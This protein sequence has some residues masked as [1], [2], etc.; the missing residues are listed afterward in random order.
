MGVRRKKKQ[1]KRQRRGS[2]KNA[3]QAVAGRI[4]DGSEWI[5]FHTPDCE[6]HEIAR[7]E[8][9]GARTHERMTI[10][11]GVCGVVRSE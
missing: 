10:T 1:L 9:P 5:Y 3:V 8:R 2:Y 7:P 6:G 11:C 4:D